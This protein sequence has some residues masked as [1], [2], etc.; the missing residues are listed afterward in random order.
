MK[1]YTGT[2]VKSSGESRTMNFLKLE[3]LPKSFLQARIK[4]PSPRKLQEGHELVWDLDKNE[5]RIFN[6]NS[7]EGDINERTIEQFMREA[8]RR[9]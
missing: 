8:C 7:I 4:D 9:I 2:Y 6:W 3:D 5:F 1:A